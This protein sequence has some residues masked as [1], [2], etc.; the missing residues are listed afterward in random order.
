M[1]YGKRQEIRGKINVI[2][3]LESVYRHRAPVYPPPAKPEATR[4]CP[5]SSATR[6]DERIQ[7]HAFHKN[8]NAFHQ[9]KCGAS[10]AW[11]R[12]TRSAVLGYVEMK[13]SAV[14]FATALSAWRHML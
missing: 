1:K 11:A 2:P 9:P 8:S 6:R 13:S 12:F 5:V 10:E 3:E 7:V 14:L 4:T